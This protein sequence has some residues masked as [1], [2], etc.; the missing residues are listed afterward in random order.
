MT[1]RDEHNRA[2]RHQWLAAKG[3]RPMKWS[4]NV[5]WGNIPESMRGG[6]IRYVEQGIPPGHF[7]M[8]V[9]TN[10]FM[11]MARRADSENGR[12]FMDYAKL[13]ANECPGD[14]WGSLE[15]VAD[16]IKRGGI[17]GNRKN[18]PLPVHQW[19]RWADQ[20]YK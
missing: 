7:L 16:W 15:K 5:I 1:A 17:A 10:D 13:L 8:A 14:C 18:E 6:V 19:S 9:F 12:L 3:L 2:F 11:E 20:E 4:D